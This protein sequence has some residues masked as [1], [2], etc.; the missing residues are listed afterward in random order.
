MRRSI[1]ILVLAVTAG[2]SAQT[3]TASPGPAA[4]VPEPTGIITGT[5]FCSDTNQPARFAK[6]SLESVHPADPAP[7][8]KGS[9]PVAASYTGNGITSIDTS[10]DG[11]FTLTKV[12][13]GSYYVIVSKS[14][15]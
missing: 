7:T 1:A 12:K 15:Y 9:I 3:H 14:G 4:V 8:A 5:V 2:A 10:L 11:S 13:P 6:V